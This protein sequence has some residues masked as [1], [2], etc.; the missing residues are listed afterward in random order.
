[1]ARDHSGQMQQASGRAHRPGTAPGP[2]RG[3]CDDQ[4]LDPQE[5]GRR[6]RAHP[7]DGAPGTDDDSGRVTRL[8]A[9]ALLHGRAA[10]TAGS[11]ERRN[12]SVA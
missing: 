3:G 10:R 12:S 1:V 7:R 2:W 4:A 6:R 11:G 8:Q 9:V 5:G